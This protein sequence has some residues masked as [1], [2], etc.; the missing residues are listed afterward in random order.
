[1][2]A[3]IIEKGADGLSSKTQRQAAGEVEMS[4]RQQKEAVRVNNVPSDQSICPELNE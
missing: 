1:M 3:A 2:R 4:P